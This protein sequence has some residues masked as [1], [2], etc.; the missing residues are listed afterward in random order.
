MCGGAP[1]HSPRIEGRRHKHSVHNIAPWSFLWNFSDNILGKN[2]FHFL[3]L[4][5]TSHFP[6]TLHNL[7]FFPHNVTEITK[8][9][10]DLR[11]SVQVLLFCS[12]FIWVSTAV[13]YFISSRLLPLASKTWCCFL[14]PTSRVS[15]SQSHLDCLP[16][17]QGSILGAL[18][19]VIYILSCSL[20]CGNH[21]LCAVVGYPPI[22][23][24]MMQRELPACQ[25]YCPSYLNM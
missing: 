7:A 24:S 3:L 19:F 14:T 15:S 16:Q 6:T 13:D 2:N 10:S 11:I 9:I 21:R 22:S 20:P 17:C 1:H 8:I 12:D 5:L 23:L 4:F 18:L 25:W